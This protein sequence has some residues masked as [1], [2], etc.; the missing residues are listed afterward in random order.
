MRQYSCSIQHISRR[1]K[2]WDLTSF[3]QR[4]NKLWVCHLVITKIVYEDTLV[5]SFPIIPKNSIRHCIFL[6]ELSLMYSGHA[7]HAPAECS[8]EVYRERCC[9]CTTIWFKW[10][11]DTNMQCP[12]T[13]SPLFHSSCLSLSRSSFLS[14][15]PCKVDSCCRGNQI[16]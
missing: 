12:L 15:S 9:C 6:A 3:C 1:I 5:S 2:S 14:V 10:E 8:S 11:L 7:V 4:E 16:N 13:I